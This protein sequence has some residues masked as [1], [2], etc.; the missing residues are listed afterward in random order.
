VKKDDKNI[1]LGK[2]LEAVDKRNKSFWKSL[3]DEQKDAF[4]AWVYMR[5]VSCCS[6]NEKKINYHYLTTV[7][8][9]VNVN[10][11]DIRHHG[12][13]QYKLMA[14]CGVGK[15]QF[16]P[17]IK[18]GKGIKKNR[19]TI[20]LADVHKHLKEDEIELLTELNSTKELKQYA[21]DL[22]LQDNEI[23]KIFN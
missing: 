10:F 14:L 3:T 8:E 17:W 19:L 7:N 12:E 11:N 15:K 20:W 5:Y 9:F 6:S 4:S 21:E 16:H 13:L 1:P 22:G 2:I 18:P 23:K